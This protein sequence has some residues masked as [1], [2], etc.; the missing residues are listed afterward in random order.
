MKTY[1]AHN[2]LFQD[3]LN[4]LIHNEKNQPVLFAAMWLYNARTARTLIATDIQHAVY[5]ACIATIAA[6][7]EYAMNWFNSDCEAGLDYILSKLK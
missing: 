2:G 1:I 7:D 4:S 5:T 3:K 6:F